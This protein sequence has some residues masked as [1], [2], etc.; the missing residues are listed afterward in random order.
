MERCDFFLYMS[1]FPTSVTKHSDKSSQIAECWRA[2]RVT[3]YIYKKGLPAP[4]TRLVVTP[5]QCSARL[6]LCK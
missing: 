3:L 2:H 1:D 4:C 5:V 6:C